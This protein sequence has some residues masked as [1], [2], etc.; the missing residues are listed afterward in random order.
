MMLLEGM[1]IAAIPVGV[2]LALILW[3][4]FEI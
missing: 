1:A 2:L 4:R 3:I